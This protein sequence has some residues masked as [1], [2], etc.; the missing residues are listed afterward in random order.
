MP[1]TARNIVE[2]SLTKQRADALWTAN[3]LPVLPMTP[4]DFDIGALLP[5]ILYMAR[6][7]HRRGKG[8]FIETFCQQEGKIQKPPTIA[9]VAKRLAKPEST[10]DSFN[11]EIGQSLLGDLLLAYCLE[12]RGRALGHIEQVQRAFPTHYLSS[13]LDLPKEANHLR[14]VPELLTVLLA[15]QET[16]QYL[17]SG[18]RNHKKQFSIGAGFADNALLA[19]FGQQ[20]IIQGQNTSN[21]TSD[22]FVEENAIN[23]GIDE[24]LAV[25]TA[26]A[27]GSAPLKAKGTDIERIFNRHPLADGAAE[28]LR[29]DLSIFILTYGGTVPRQAF[30]Q[31]LEAGIGLGMTNLLLSTANLLTVWEVTGQVPEQK[32]QIS[33]PLFIDCSHGQDKILRDLSEGSASE[34]IR[35]F[36]RLPLLMMLLRVLDDRVRIDR[37]LR[38]SLPSNIPNATEWINLLGEIYQERHP[39][40]EAIADAL[41]EDCQRLAELLENDPDIAEPEIAHRLRHSQGDPAL[42]LAETLC[43]LMGDKLQRTHYVRCLENAMMTDQPNGLSIK[44]RV[45]RSQSGSNRRI[46]LRSIVLTT[47]L[48][49]FLVH[50][51]LYRTATEPAPLSLQGFIKLLRDRYGLYIAQEPPGQPIPQEMLLRNKAYLERRLRDLGLLI[52]VNDAES[53]KQL[54]P[55]YRVEISNVA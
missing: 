38:D 13:W 23:F 48:L 31:M 24:L 28:T 33:I 26:Q 22:F 41:D 46:D 55:H 29:E 53:M 44:R 40:S 12:N 34:G 51:H 5:A 52:G 30:L 36:E 45:L 1:R 11:D 2:E 49:E 39:R 35:R 37:R 8:K 19:L 47:P 42:R 16:G 54:K 21:L 4:Q 20:M 7:G 6:W 14:G 17:E 27:C 50:R 25:R 18:N 10:L 3:Y 15:Q 9:D 32:Q 43:E